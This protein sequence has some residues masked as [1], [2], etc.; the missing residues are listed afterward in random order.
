MAIPSPQAK[1]SPSLNDLRRSAECYLM[2]FMRKPMLTGAGIPALLMSALFLSS[3][4]DAA[5]ANSKGYWVY[6]GTYT[7]KTG[8]KGIYAY[9]FQPSTGDLVPIG[10]VAETPSPSF[11]ATDRGGKYLYAVNEA[12]GKTGSVSA[13]SIDRTS[14]KLNP[15]NTVSSRGAGP[16]HLMVDNTGKMLV[17]ANYDSGSVA[18]MPIGTDGKLGEAASFDQHTG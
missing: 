4:F 3:P 8:S 9:R 5:P 14:G 1:P 18:A 16:C 15:L 6:V 10:L 17:V 7:G 11:L 2:E 13:Y 12:G